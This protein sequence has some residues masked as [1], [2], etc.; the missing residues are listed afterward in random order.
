V[1]ERKKSK[2]RSPLLSSTVLLAEINAYSCFKQQVVAILFD[3][4]EGNH[5]K[6]RATGVGMRR[7]CL[8]VYL[9][10]DE[11]SFVATVPT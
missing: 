7:Y 6:K 3:Q 2:E 1:N 8:S 4:L 9:P 5:C 10:K 11:S